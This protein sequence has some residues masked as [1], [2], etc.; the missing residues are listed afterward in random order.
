MWSDTAQFRLQSFL[1]LKNY[2]KSEGL[3]AKLYLIMDVRG[4][5]SLRCIMNIL[6][7]EKEAR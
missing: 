3:L 6:F 5:Q 2:L 7:M 1:G 4:A